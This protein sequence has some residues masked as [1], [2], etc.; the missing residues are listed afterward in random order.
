M[1]SLVVLAS[2]IGSLIG[3]WVPPCSITSATRSMTPTSC[4][5]FHDMLP[6]SG[7]GGFCRWIPKEPSKKPPAFST[8]FFFVHR[9][10]PVA[11]FQWDSLET[12]LAAAFSIMFLAHHAPNGRPKRP[13]SSPVSPV[14]STCTAGAGTT[15][16]STS[17]RH[18]PGRC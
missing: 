18:R 11:P 15:P 9:P 1:I 12:F 5:L 8:R 17:A 3:I 6:G 14:R 7:N 2:R 13:V 4:V 16:S 10:R